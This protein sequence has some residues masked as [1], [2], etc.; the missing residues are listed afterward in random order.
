[1]KPV[2]SNEY[3][4]DILKKELD[5]DYMPPEVNRRLQQI[6]FELPDPLPV[7]RRGHPRLKAVY[8][9]LSA[10]AAAVL[11]LFGL[12]A[13]NPA[14]AE[15][16]PLIGGFFR[17]INVGSYD[18]DTADTERIEQHAVIPDEESDGSL[19][20]QNDAYEITVQS[21]YFDGRFLHSALELKSDIDIRE[22]NY[23]FETEIR[24]NETA[25]YAPQQGFSENSQTEQTPYIQWMSTGNGSYVGNLKFIVPEAYR[26]GKQLQVEYLFSLKDMA[27]YYEALY[28]AEEQPESP[29]E[30]AEAAI[31]EL[32]TNGTNAIRF[33][34]IPDSSDTVQI[35]ANCESA[36]AL[37]TD[38]YTGPA[39]TEIALQVP[40]DSDFG[41]YA[42][43]Y[44]EDGRDISEFQ[45]G[46]NSA[47]TGSASGPMDTHFAFGGLK[48][49]YETAVLQ[50]FIREDN[51]DQGIYRIAE[52]T[53]DTVNRTV[54]AS[55]N[56]KNPDSILYDNP[57]LRK[58]TPS[59]QPTYR[60]ADA[61]LSLSEGYAV[62]FLSSGGLHKSAYLT[63]V[64]PE[65]YRD[66]RVEL[67]IDGQL[68]T[69]EATKQ[70]G[71]D[72][73]RFMPLS[74]Y[75]YDPHGICGEQDGVQY[76]L[77]SGTIER[78]EEVQAA[79]NIQVLSMGDVFFQ[80]EDTATVKLYDAASG[81]LLHEETQTLTLP[82]NA[83]IPEGFRLYK[84]PSRSS[85]V[86]ADPNLFA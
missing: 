4:D 17:Q 73:N 52:F 55:E 7:K 77:S 29:E 2:K 32:G 82:E 1:M 65:N 5:L 79:L 6:Y 66:L 3:F 35:T 84:Q 18:A 50:V 37:V 86:I 23:M 12:N 48:A 74:E 9:S 75:V 40:I 54:T 38:V 47:F 46:S 67:Y 76:I 20:A 34:A 11:L 71:E 70:N 81:A 10:V 69:V 53:I 57:D 41:S 19:T 26:T 56:H 25:V 33:E 49:E 15:E 42:R 13:V 68:R 39:G 72:N 28:N 63:F 78:P 62:E 30:T 58:V 45:S 60:A 85:Y 27:E 24:L 16:I 61:E 51:E 31:T 43:L 83:E 80:M 44:T 21:V 36:G 59:V 14:F 8:A 22:D 64:T